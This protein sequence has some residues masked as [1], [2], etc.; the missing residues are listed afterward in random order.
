MCEKCAE[1]DQQIEFCRQIATHSDT[2]LMRE[3]IVMLIESYFAEKTALHPTGAD[4]NT[5][6]HVKRA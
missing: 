6:E 5:S 4:E 3:G 2:E 1:L